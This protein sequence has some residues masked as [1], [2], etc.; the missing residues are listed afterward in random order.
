MALCYAASQC[1]IGAHC[2]HSTSTFVCCVFA[3]PIK[4]CTRKRRNRKWKKNTPADKYWTIKRTKVKSMN[5]QMEIVAIIQIEIDTNNS[6]ASVEYVNILAL[7]IV[8][9]VYTAWNCMLFASFS[10]NLYQHIFHFSSCA[11]FFL[12]FSLA[13]ENS[14][15][16]W[17]FHR[18]HAIRT[19]CK[20]KCG[21][22]MYANMSNPIHN[23]Y[24]FIC[25]SS[26]TCLTNT[27]LK[28]IVSNKIQLRCKDRTAKKCV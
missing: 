27:T 18:N 4:S 21:K 28:R 2:L 14:R 23:S 1:K 3:V 17:L 6:K 22:N 5:T 8:V 19:L 25:N 16:T 7:S 10:M 20:C 26:F 9:T 11:P 13:S 12:H 15:S 24:I